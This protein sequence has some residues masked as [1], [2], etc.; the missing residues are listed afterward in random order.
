MTLF[1][2]F[3]LCLRFP[4][5][6]RFSS[7]ISHPLAGVLANHRQTRFHQY[8]KSLFQGQTRRQIAQSLR[9]SAQKPKH[10]S[11]SEVHLITPWIAD[12]LSCTSKGGPLGN[13]LTGQASIQRVQTSQK[14]R[15]PSSRGWSCTNGRS[16]STFENL[17]LGPYSGVITSWLRA[18]S[19]RPAWSA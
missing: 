18:Y 2:Q 7:L 19:P 13:A 1:H 6:V 10:F 12:L 16:V 11:A 8:P 4:R 14:R 15:T 9:K 3:V 17:T 5:L